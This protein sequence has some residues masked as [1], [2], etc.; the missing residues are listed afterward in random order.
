M[1]VGHFH[2]STKGD[3]LNTTEFAEATNSSSDCDFCAYG[4]PMSLGIARSH[5]LAER[6]ACGLYDAGRSEH[7]VALVILMLKRFVELIV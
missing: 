7:I 4:L 2:H 3:P 6:A 5:P 1:V